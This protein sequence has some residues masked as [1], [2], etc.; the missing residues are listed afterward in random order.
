[1]P[2]SRTQS[3]KIPILSDLSPE[4]LDAVNALHTGSILCGDVGSGKSRTSLAYYEKVAKGRPLYIITTARKRDTKDWE[5]EAR[6][7]GIRLRQVDSWNNIAKYTDVKKAFFIFDEQRVVGYGAWTKAFLKI[8][9]ENDW[10]LLSATPGDR[11][12]DYIPVFIANGFY[13]NKSQFNAEHVVWNYHCPY[14]VVDRYMGQAKLIRLRNSILVNIAFNRSTVRHDLD[15]ICSYDRERYRYIEKNRFDPDEKKMLDTAASYCACL[16]KAINVSEDKVERY[17]DILKKHP[18]AV[19]FYNYDYELDILLHAH[20]A[21]GTVI[22]QW[23]GHEHEQIPKA[24]RW[25]YL[26]QYNAG[27]EGWNCIST[28]TMIF[29]SESYSYRMMKQASGRIDRRNTPFVDLYYYHLRTGAKIDLSI[30]K[31]LKSK[32]EFNTAAFAGFKTKEKLNEHDKKNSSQHDESDSR[33]ERLQA[34]QIRRIRMG[35]TSGEKGWSYS[36]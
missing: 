24:E 28:D 26:V 7:Y 4:Q 33:K 14:P 32:K 6:P 5:D 20:Y 11:W 18:K 19:V 22:R 36:A 9:K 8:T 13:K 16:R 35:Q 17:L 21:K 15:V 23:N 34:E 30:Q 25:V 10:I 27:N 12:L 29:Y 1:M 2:T 31:A 3:T